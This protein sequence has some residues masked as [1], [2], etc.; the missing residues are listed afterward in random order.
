MITND[1]LIPVSQFIAESEQ[2]IQVAT[3]IFENYTAARAIILSGFFDRLTADLKAQ[4]PGW[5]FHYSAPFF[6]ERYGGYFFWKK[7][8]KEQYR[9]GIEALQYGA[10][11]VF[12]VWRDFDLFKT[13]PL[14][15]ELL[16]AVKEEYPRATSRNYYEAEI[17]MTSPAADWRTPKSLWRIHSDET[18]RAEV[19]TFLLQMVTLTEEHI[20]TLG[21]R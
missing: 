4:L 20:D 9:I 15:A 13:I 16:E 8:W 12:G 3:A 5:R 19:K 21:K 6:E 10:S 1:D 17:Q 18:F 2:N 7:S 14:S 11:M